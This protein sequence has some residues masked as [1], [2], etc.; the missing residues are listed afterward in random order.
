MR[1]SLLHPGR[2]PLLHTIIGENVTKTGPKQFWPSDKPLRRFPSSNNT[3]LTGC[4]CVSGLTGG[5]LLL[6]TVDKLV[7]IGSLVAR[8][9]PFILPQR[10]HVFVKLLRRKDTEEVN[11]KTIFQKNDWLIKVCKSYVKPYACQL[12][13]PSDV[14]IKNL[15]KLG[16]Q[17][18]SAGASN[19]ERHRR[20]CNI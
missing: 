13:R 2:F 1:W 10:L 11:D 12:I 8:S 5:H 19:A 20:L 4:R 7:L 16:L 14:L 18:A 9:D 15:F 17:C 3:N 6:C